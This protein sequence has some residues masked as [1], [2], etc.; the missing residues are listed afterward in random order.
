MRLCPPRTRGAGATTRPQAALLQLA[1]RRRLEISHPLVPPLL[2]QRPRHP[3]DFRPGALGPTA[4]C[5]RSSERSGGSAGCVPSGPIN[6]SIAEGVTAGRPTPRA[7]LGL[8]ENLHPAN[9]QNRPIRQRLEFQR[10]LRDDAQGA[11]RAGEQFAE[12]V[13]GDIF[14]DAAAGFE[15]HA[16]AIDGADADHI[17]A[18][19]APAKAARPAQ[20][21]GHQ[22]RRASPARL[23]AVDRQPLPFGGQQSASAASVMPASTVIVMSRA[24]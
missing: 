13:T 9:G 23:R 8:V 17:I 2:L 21:R 16:A 11:Q 5:P 20:G 10:H 1:G 18:D 14:H 22:R 4:R 6:S 3:I 19:R 15:R 12:I 24:G 7:T